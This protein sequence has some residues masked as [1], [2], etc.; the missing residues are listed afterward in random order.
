[1]FDSKTQTR[2]IDTCAGK[3]RQPS[4][5]RPRYVKHG[6]EFNLFSCFAIVANLSCQ[7]RTG[8]LCFGELKDMKA[9]HDDELLEVNGLIDS[10]YSSI[11]EKRRASNEGV[12]CQEEEGKIEPRLFSMSTVYRLF[13]FYIRTL[14]RSSPKFESSCGIVEFKTCAAKQWGK[15]VCS[16]IASFSFT[17]SF[18]HSPLPLI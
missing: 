2:V 15:N 7:I 3:I 17:R 10:E 18:T 12:K 5:K 4:L 6:A 8:K 1:M 13:P 16:A 9:Y 11:I 14:I